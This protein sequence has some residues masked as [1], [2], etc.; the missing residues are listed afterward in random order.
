MKNKCPVCIE[1]LKTWSKFKDL[2]EKEGI[3][4]AVCGSILN[5]IDH[6]LFGESRSCK[7]CSDFRTLDLSFCSKCNK[8]YLKCPNCNA[9][10]TLN[11]IPVETKTLIVCPTC[12]KRLLY[13]SVDYQF[14]G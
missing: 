3:G 8:Y 6:F 1:E 12:S 7:K 2:H 14:G 4:L 10:V 5:G 11:E 9:Y 13:A